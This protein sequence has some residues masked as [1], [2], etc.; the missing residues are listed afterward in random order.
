V[1][2]ASHIWAVLRGAALECGSLL[3][4]SLSE[5]ARAGI[6]AALPCTAGKPAWPKRQQAA[7]L[8]SAFGAVG[9][10]ELSHGLLGG[11]G[12]RQSEW[13]TGDGAAR[14]PY[15]A[16]ARSCNPLRAPRSAL[17]EFTTQGVVAGE[18]LAYS[19]A[20]ALWRGLHR[21]IGGWRI[22]RFVC[23]RHPSNAGT[24]PRIR[25]PRKE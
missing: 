19:V 22:H 24:L 13:R 4:L 2:T 12:V 21:L 23:M 9:F 10:P 18:R 17:S 1:T 6:V 7:A 14:P 20:G 25:E 8:Q 5:L 15:Y 3:P 11:E 16:V